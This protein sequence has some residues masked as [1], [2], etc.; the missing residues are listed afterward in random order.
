MFS[1]S[2]KVV[3]GPR[4]RVLSTGLI[5]LVLAVMPTAAHAVIPG[6][7][8]P[9]GQITRNVPAGMYGPLLGDVA[10]DS[11]G[12]QQLGDVTGSTGSTGPQGATGSTGS[13]GPQGAT[14]ATG[15][16]GGA[17][18]DG[19]DGARGQD[20]AP[21]V[22]GADGQDGTDGAQG[23]AGPQGEAGADG[24]DG[25][26]GADGADGVD[27]AQGP[28]GLQGEQGEQGVQGAAGADGVDG[29]QGPAGPAGPQGE[30]GIQGETGAAGAD[31]EDS[32]PSMSGLPGGT[33]AWAMPF[34]RLRS[35]TAPRTC[36]CWRRMLGRCGSISATASPLTVPCRN[37]RKVAMH[38]WCVPDRL[39]APASFW[40]TYPGPVRLTP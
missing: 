26:D 28:A 2:S 36:G 33:P 10:L 4:E 31:G 21:G 35:L 7:E 32:M 5:A 11:S 25:A 38:G 15:P 29:A 22:D 20:G 39:W 34:C 17:G 13:T 16:Q 14:G 18:S 3:F 37:R 24:V 40:L 8:A 6:P 27:G 12:T 30:Q 23:S 19:V 1:P 9:R